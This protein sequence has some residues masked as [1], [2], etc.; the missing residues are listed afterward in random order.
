MP[1][2]FRFLG[3]MVG[4]FEVRILFPSISFLFAHLGASLGVSYTFCPLVEGFVFGGSSLNVV[5]ADLF[6]LLRQSID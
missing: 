4:N 6:P 3:S 5:L 1:L 2:F